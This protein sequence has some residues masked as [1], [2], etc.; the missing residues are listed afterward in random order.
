VTLKDI[1]LENATKEEFFKIAE[2]ATAEHETIHNMP[3]KVT[4]DDVVMA[5][6]GTDAYVKNYKKR[7][8]WSDE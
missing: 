7:H 4:P 2:V 3:F 1:H 5:L 8:G 6:L